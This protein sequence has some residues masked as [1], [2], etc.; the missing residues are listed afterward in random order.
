[1]TFLRS[2]RI[3]AA[4]GKPLLLTGIVCALLITLSGCNTPG[5]LRSRDR[6]RN[7]VVF[8]LPGIDGKSIWNRNIA[9][10]LDDGGVRAAIEVY[11]WTLGVPGST[12]INITTY[13]RNREQ[14]ARLARRIV[15]QRTRYPGSPVYL[16]GHSAGGAIAAFALEALP[17]GRQI[18]QAILLAPALSPEYDLTTALRRT[19]F[20][21]L[22]LYSEYDVGFLLVGTTAVGT[23]DR[24]HTASAGYVGF[25]VPAELNK[26]NQTL[27]ADKLRQVEWNPRLKQYGASGTH[28]GWASR[29]FARDYLAPI[30]LKNSA[31]KVVE[32]AIQPPAD[33][34][35]PPPAA[36]LDA[37]S[38]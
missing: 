37:E 31:R 13:S 36:P 29:D 12:V 1:M 26:A 5:Y 38:E 8:V 4:L 34:A 17:P 25:R 33:E 6:Y 22:N 20:G 15:D 16:V 2:V 23:A 32:D 9:M 3:F 28:M 35:A 19:R 7:G 24:S 27:Y 30:I 21:I 10:G 14:A 11:D 18:D